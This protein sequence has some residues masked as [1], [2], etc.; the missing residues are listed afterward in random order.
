MENKNNNLFGKKRRVIYV[1]VQ[2]DREK[3]R[4]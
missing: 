2:R 1:R 3:K 4:E